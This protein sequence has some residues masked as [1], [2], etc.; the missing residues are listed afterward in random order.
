[1]EHGMNAEEHCLHQFHVRLNL[2]SSHSAGGGDGIV[3]E[4]PKDQCLAFLFMGSDV[5]GNG[6]FRVGLAAVI[7]A[8]SFLASSMRK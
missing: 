6:R 7:R 4:P 5:G 1:M 8:T 2:S 3:P